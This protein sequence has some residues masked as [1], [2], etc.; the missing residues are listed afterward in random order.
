MKKFFSLAL[1]VLCLSTQAYADK[2]TASTTLP[3]NGKPEHV[4]TMVSGNGA[5]VSPT[6]TPVEGDAAN[7]LFAF[8]AVDGVNGAYYI[9]SHNAK[10]WLSYT[11]AS[12]YSTGASFIKMS[13]TKVEGA[14]FKVDNYADDFYQISPYTTA[15]TAQATYLNYF[16]GVSACS[17]KT[18]GLWTDNGSKDGGS[19]YTFAEY[20]IAER[21]Y[22][23]S[24]PEGVTLK[25][26][27]VEYADGS[28]ITVEGSLDK[29][30][31][32]VTAPEG[33]FAVVSVNDAEN[34]ITVNVATLPTLPACEPYTNAWVYPKQQDNVGVANISE[35]NGVYVLNNKVLAA[36]FMKVGDALYFAGSDAMN[37]VAGTEPFTVAFGSGD[38]VPASAMTLKSV[39][40]ETLAAN[41]TAIGGA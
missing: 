36:G 16:G 6:T 23:I 20:V 9:Y 14:Y 29:S 25:I 19:R 30:T 32:S 26:A 31:V 22:T 38:N 28:T 17:G 40:T 8:Y 41:A 2:V 37:L 10:Q 34:T 1:A 15:G 12:N 21:T 27:G 35:D 7:G 11:K 39:A 4:Y 3:S 18:L 13:D 24:L 33:K 5:Y